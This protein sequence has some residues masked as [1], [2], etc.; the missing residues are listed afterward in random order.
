MLSGWL[1]SQ[2]IGLVVCIGLT[3]SLCVTTL[4]QFDVKLLPPPSSSCNTQCLSVCLFTTSR[5]SYCSDLRE[6]FTTIVDLGKEV[7]VK[8]WKSDPD[9][10]SGSDP[11]ALAEVCALIMRVFNLSY[12]NWCLF[13]YVVFSCL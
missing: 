13:N 10:E 6:S 2:S 7:P 8:F 3:D 12:I 11:P 9:T 1:H 5:K 4:P